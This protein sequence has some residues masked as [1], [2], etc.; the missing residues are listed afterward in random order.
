MI[1]V[2]SGKLWLLSIHPKYL[3]AFEADIKLLNLVI[4][5]EVIE[6]YYFLTPCENNQ[7]AIEKLSHNA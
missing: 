2:L 7:A 3:S 4:L 6:Y 1:V 5:Y